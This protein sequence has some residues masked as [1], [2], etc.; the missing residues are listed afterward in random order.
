MNNIIKYEYLEI[1]KNIQDILSIYISEYRINRRFKYR[2]V[3]NNPYYIDDCYNVLHMSLLS[4][5]LPEDA[6]I[7][8][9]LYYIENLIQNY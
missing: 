5:N 4:H 2:S 3:I 8:D 6:S 1:L 9:A 7:E